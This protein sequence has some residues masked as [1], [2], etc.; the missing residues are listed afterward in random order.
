[1][2]NKILLS[3]LIIAIGFGCSDNFEPIV[4]SGNLIL[5]TEYSYELTISCFCTSS[6]RGPHKIRIKNNMIIDYELISDEENNEELDI[7]QF[8]IDALVQRVDELTAQ[9]PVIKDIQVHPDYD[10]P[11]SVY[12]DVDERIADEEWGYEIKNFKVLED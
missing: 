6:Y 10:F 1:M 7:K 4:S 3:V 12:I 11:V 5:P 8:T 2:M 9:D